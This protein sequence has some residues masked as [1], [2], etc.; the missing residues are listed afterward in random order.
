[1]GIILAVYFL[2]SF[3]ESVKSKFVL[4]AGEF[5]Y[6]RVDLPFDYNVAQGLRNP[7]LFALIAKQILKVKKSRLRSRKRKSLL[8]QSLPAS[9]AEQMI[10]C[11]IIKSLDISPLRS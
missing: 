7:R 11:L 9:Y 8:G 4:H 5:I 2:W 6:P 10:A 1:V 3:A